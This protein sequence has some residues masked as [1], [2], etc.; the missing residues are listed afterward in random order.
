VRQVTA[1]KRYARALAAVTDWCRTHRHLSIPEQHAE[2]V[3]KMRGH[4]AYYGISGNLTHLLSPQRAC[5]RRS[6]SQSTATKDR[7]TSKSHPMVT[8]STKRRTNHRSFN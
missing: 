3:M 1:K 2:L 7:V 6:W 5:A 4:Y 8:P